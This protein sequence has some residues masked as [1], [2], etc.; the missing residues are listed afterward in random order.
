VREPDGQPSWHKLLK[1]IDAES[2]PVKRRNLEVVARHAVAEVAEDIPG[3][4]V[5]LT[6]NSHHEVWGITQM[7]NADGTAAVA[8]HYA[9]L[10]E[11]VIR[12]LAPGEMPHLGPASRAVPA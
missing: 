1:A 12:S 3:V 6:P 4:L 8:A 7:N 5:T 10:V 9:G 11:A 2:D